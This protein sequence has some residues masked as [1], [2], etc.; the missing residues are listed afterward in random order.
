MLNRNR[1]KRYALLAAVLAAATSLSGCVKGEG[2][3]NEGAFTEVP[4]KVEDAGAPQAPEGI[5]EAAFPYTW[6]RE[7]NRDAQLPAS[8][9]YRAAGRAPRIGNQGSLGTCCQ[10][11]RPHFP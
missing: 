9:D 5:M 10:R 6:N 4:E 7:E 1:R 3:E 11:I 2:K 8:Y